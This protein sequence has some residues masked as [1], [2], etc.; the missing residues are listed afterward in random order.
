MKS[1]KVCITTMSTVASLLFKSLATKHTAVKWSIVAI[2][3]LVY[4]ACRSC[5]VSHLFVVAI[6]AL[7]PLHLQR[8]SLFVELA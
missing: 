1:S 2:M 3:L 6:V 7:L 5:H 8:P 4:S